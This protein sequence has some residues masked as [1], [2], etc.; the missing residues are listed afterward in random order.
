MT[1]PFWSNDITILF[2]KNYIFQL[3]PL[4]QMTF[5][6]KL[7]AISRLVIFVSVLGFLITKNWNLIIIETITLA[8]IFSIYKISGT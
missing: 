1:T 6:E 3:W 8:I 4:Q 2:N 7:N 5:E